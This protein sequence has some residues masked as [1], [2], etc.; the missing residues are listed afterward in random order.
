MDLILDGKEAF[1]KDCRANLIGMPYYHCRECQ[2]FKSPDKNEGNYRI[3]VCQACQEKRLQPSKT[4]SYGLRQVV[5]QKDGF[6]I[7]I[8]L[9]VEMNFTGADQKSVLYTLAMKERDEIC[10]AEDSS[11]VM[12]LYLLQEQ[13]LSLKQLIFHLSQYPQKLY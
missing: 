2:E 7:A 8:G 13:H 11:A 5:T 12:P 9:R 1:C 3:N 10:V 6:S 4:V